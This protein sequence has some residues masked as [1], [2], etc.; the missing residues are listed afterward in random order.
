MIDIWSITAEFVLRWMPL[1]LMYDK[2]T[3]VHVIAC[4]QISHDAAY[5]QAPEVYE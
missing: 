3:L 2:S 4:C 1:D 5:C